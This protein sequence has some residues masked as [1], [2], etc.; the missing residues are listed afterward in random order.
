MPTRK[1][2]LVLALT[3]G[4]FLL[5]GISRAAAY[6][7][8]VINVALLTLFI[9]DRRRLPVRSE[10]EAGREHQRVF[11]LVEQ[12]RVE[13]AVT[14]RSAHPLRG[15]LQDNPPHAFRRTPERLEVAVPP[16]SERRMDYLVFPVERGRF[17]FSAAVMRARAPFGLAF[18]DFRL[19]DE[20]AQEDTFTVY[21]TISS[22]T[23]RQVAAFAEHVE[24][25]YHRLRRQVE[26]TSPSSLRE[27]A[28]GD[29]YRSINWKATARYDKPMVTEH[30]T[31]RNQSIY[32]FVDC[33]RLMRA[34]VGRL[35]KLD[36]AVNACADLAR[37][38]LDRGDTVGV[39]CFS[40]SVK[41][42]LDAKGKRDHFLAVRDALATLEADNKATN[43]HDAVNM[44]V[45]RAKK[46]SLCLFLTAFSESE[47]TWE[48]MARL[49]SMRTRHV[50]AVVSLAE[51]D[52]RDALRREPRGFEGA[53]R[54]L[55]ASDL[56]EEVALFAQR[57]RQRRGYFLELPADELSL[58]AVQTYLDAKSRGLL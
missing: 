43:Y 34:P 1:M 7:G 41:V 39:C 13:L 42:W 44:F 6:T 47:S 15:A 19:L 53:C 10:V 12:N 58:G 27:W 32:I 38:A 29:N 23:P 40:D 18:R 57:L 52:L 31:D 5:A 22:A 4:L 21:P 33:G 48:L 25:G 49:L 11:S 28:P 54:K 56:A 26:G 14:N 36:Y 17:A 55:A 37:V 3:A 45:A 2:L 46:R 35:R 16:R 50:P 30:D 8:L 24:T 20:S 51:P 9:L